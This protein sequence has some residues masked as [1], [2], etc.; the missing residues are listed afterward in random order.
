MTAAEITKLSMPA[1]RLHS[2]PGRDAI[3]V[4]R[5]CVTI[6]LAGVTGLYA[7]F[8][9]TALRFQEW[10]HRPGDHGFSSC[11]KASFFE[12][13]DPCVGTFDPSGYGVLSVSVLFLIM[14]TPLA[15]LIWMPA[16]LALKGKADP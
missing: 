7:L 16:S 13:G 11:T 12:S 2:R 3:F 14:A 15:A 5:L 10:P 6:T 9:L 4:H 1:L 8:A